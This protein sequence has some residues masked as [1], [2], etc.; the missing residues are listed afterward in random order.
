M[1]I[2]IIELKKRLDIFFNGNEA[3][4][5]RYI[6]K[7]GAVLSMKNINDLRA[8]VEKEGPK[9]EVAADELQEAPVQE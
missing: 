3:L 7:Y 4:V 2:D 5:D 1:T 6:E 8:L 9:E